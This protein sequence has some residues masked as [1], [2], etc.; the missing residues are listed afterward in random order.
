MWYQIWLGGTPNQTTIA[1]TFMNKVKVQ[2]LEKVFEPLFYSWKHERQQ[3]ESFG[4]FTNRVVSIKSSIQACDEPFVFYGLRKNI[5][6]SKAKL[7]MKKMDISD[8]ARSHY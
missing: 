8:S 2:E 5:S 1:K 3:G 4:K 7:G 6:A